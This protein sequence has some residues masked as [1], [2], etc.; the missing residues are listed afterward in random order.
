MQ[1]RTVTVVLYYV[2]TPNRRSANERVILLKL[3]KQQLI[4]EM[5]E[6][7]KTWLWINTLHSILKRKHLLNM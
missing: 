2:D 6:Y 3:Q 4:D 5:I 1:E 7:S